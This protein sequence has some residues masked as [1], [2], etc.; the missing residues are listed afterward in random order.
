MTKQQT[1]RKVKLLFKNNL[2]RNTLDHQ[3]FYLI[4]HKLSHKQ[5]YSLLKK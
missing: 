2:H 4:F 5:F 1:I 3:F